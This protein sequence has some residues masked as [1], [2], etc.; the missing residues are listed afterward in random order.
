M[1]LGRTLF[2]V[3]LPF[4]LACGGKSDYPAG[5]TPDGGT[6]PTVDSGTTPP[7][8]DGGTSS[9][10][11]PSFDGGG[12]LPLGCAPNDGETGGGAT[13]YP[14]CTFV[15]EQACQSDSACGCGCSCQC[16][17]CNCLSTAPGTCASDTDCGPACSAFTCVNEACVPGG[18]SQWVGTWVGSPSYSTSS[19]TGTCSTGAGESAG[20]GG[21]GGGSYTVVVSGAGNELTFVLEQEDQSPPFCALP[22]AVSGTSATLIAGSTCATPAPA[23]ACSGAE[24]A[25]SVDTYLSGSAKIS[26]STM[27]L[28]TTDIY[29]E[30]SLGSIEGPCDPNAGS[31]QINV[32]TFNIELSKA[33][34]GG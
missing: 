22:F 4:A 34:G 2:P 11:P 5:A 30:P 25:V 16:G 26:G 9:P 6:T 10:L 17:V 32:T 18:A 12:G 8:H 20:M 24:S 27:T 19:Y 31:S 13:S 28:T 15:N 21:G 7:V 14:G 29:V 33:N 1:H 23:A 3:L